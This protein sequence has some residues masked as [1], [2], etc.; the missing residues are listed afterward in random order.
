ML[1][2]GPLQV[3]GQVGGGDQLPSLQSAA[4]PGFD[5]VSHAPVR[6]RPRRE[7]R[8]RIAEQLDVAEERR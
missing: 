3:G 7:V 8:R 2:P 1:K 5:G 6:Q 4:M